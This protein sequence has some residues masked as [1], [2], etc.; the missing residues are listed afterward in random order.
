MPVVAFAVMMVA[1]PGVTVVTVVP[2]IPVTLMA[3]IVAMVAAAVTGRRAIITMTGMSGLVDNGRTFVPG[4][5]R[6][7]NQYPGTRQQGQSQ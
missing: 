1:F 2:P 7:R 6:R 3:S 5:R 4:L